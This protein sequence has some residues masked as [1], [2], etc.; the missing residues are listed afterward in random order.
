[1][2]KVLFVLL[3][4]FADWELASLAAALN[5]EPENG[6]AKRYLVETVSLKKEP[7]KSIGGITV[8]PDYALNEV[9]TD[10]SALILIGGN[11]WRKKESEDVMELVHYAISRNAVLGAICD[12]AYFIGSHGILNE[13]KHT[14]N[15][16]EELQEVPLYTGEKYFEAKQAVRDGSIVTANGSAIFEFGKEVMLAMDAFPKAE[17]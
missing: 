4:E 15:F 8:L 14:A 17:I 11:S 3:E 1:M 2:E 16:L 5:E 6:Q 9:P 7:I 12:A 13:V 10:F